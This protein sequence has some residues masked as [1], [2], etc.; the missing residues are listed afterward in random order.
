MALATS[1]TTGF[2]VPEVVFY[3]D[4]VCPY[5][6]I[7]SERLPDVIRFT[8]ANVTWKPVVLG[9][10]YGMTQAPQGKDGS[11][12]DVFAPAKRALAAVDFQRESK[13]YGLPIKFHPEH[14]V[15]SVDAGRLLCA[16]PNEHRGTLAREIFRAYFFDNANISSRATLL[17]IARNLKLTSVA[18]PTHAGPFSLSPALSFQLDESVF[19]DVNREDQLRANTQEAFERGAFG[20]PS[21][22]IPSRE[23]LFWGQDRMVLLEAEL[24][25]I[26][27]NK[28]VES[29]RQ[30]ERLHPRCLRTGRESRK[31]QLKFW[32]DFSSPWSYLAWS[33]LERIQRE[34]GPGLTIELVPF[35]LGALFKGIGTPMVPMESMSEA[36]RKYKMQDLQ[37]WN[38][39][40]TAVNAQ[41]Y[42][43]IDGPSMAWP[44]EFPIRS[45]TALRV[46]LLERKTIPCLF[47]AAWR[48]NRRISDDQVVVEVL[49]AAGFDG[50][51][52]VARSLA[53]KD[54]LRHNTEQ[55]Q[56]LGLCGAPTFQFKDQLVFGGDRINVVQDLVLGWSVASLELSPERSKL[57]ASV[58]GFAHFDYRL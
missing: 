33:Q 29:I 17:R 12:T 16:F 35:L 5:A 24:I 31:R 18:T 3:F 2:T 49:T 38:R 13:R 8:G 48:D 51:T 36:R 40:W 47:R 19:S 39:Y 11:A 50:K 25:S 44:D 26:K 4:V 55:A 43:P 32:F 53:A 46:A 1:P 58:A 54:Q 42:P 22:Y 21:F 37:D 41:E 28:P 23:K 14:P 27:L 15:R 7:A 56:A 10:L 30:L 20:V 9:A 34:S 6:F 57:K 52:L 45:V